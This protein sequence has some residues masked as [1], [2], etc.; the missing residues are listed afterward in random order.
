[1]SDLRM[2]L[3]F[4]ALFFVSLART[5]KASGQESITRN[6]VSSMTVSDAVN[7]LKSEDWK[8]WCP[9]VTYASTSLVNV[10]AF[11]LALIELR[12]RENKI[13]EKW[14][15]ETSD[16]KKPRGLNEQFGG[17]GYGECLGELNTRIVSLK[18]RRAV[19]ALIR[20]G[21]P[22]AVVEF[23]SDAASQMITWFRSTKDIS[24]RAAVVQALGKIQD[25]G[26]L[27]AELRQ[28]S[29][30]VVFGAAKDAS[31]IVREASIRTVHHFGKT[32][33]IQFLK[34]LSESDERTFVRK[35]DGTRVYPIRDAAQKE[36]D[37]L[38]KVK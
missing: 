27:P 30:D 23:G 34:K 7:L 29:K 10:E 3:V 31:P 17:E 33:A 6:T 25:K 12:E 14:W 22:G 35:T 38:S 1:M 24:G 28:Q 32:E 15:G 37:R 11:R 8:R 16:G 13:S 19:G 21:D 5:A 18:D 26:V 36:I 4:G 2:R 9:V 20:S